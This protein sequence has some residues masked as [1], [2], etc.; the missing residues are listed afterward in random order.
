MSSHVSPWLPCSSHCG[1]QPP[2]STI[3]FFHPQLG[4]CCHSGGCSKARDKAV[5]CA[6]TLHLQVQRSDCTDVLPCL[7][8][9]GMTNAAESAG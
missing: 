4:A 5:L 1:F 7:V 3:S 2:V 9:M 8:N 6:L